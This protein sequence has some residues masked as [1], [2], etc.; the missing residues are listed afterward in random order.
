MCQLYLNFTKKM[1]RFI[2]SYLKK[3]KIFPRHMGGGLKGFI[4]S[5]ET[6]DNDT[7]HGYYLISY[8]KI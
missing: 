8:A 2:G 7:Q 6:Y 5:M 4:V 1:K 3:E